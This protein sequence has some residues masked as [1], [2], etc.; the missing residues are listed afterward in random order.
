VLLKGV[1][2]KHFVLKLDANLFWLVIDGI[3]LVAG[4]AMLWNA[5]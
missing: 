5:F 2:A 4:L 3:M 1:I